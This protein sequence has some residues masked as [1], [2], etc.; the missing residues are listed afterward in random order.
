MNKL[1]IPDI[2]GPEY[3]GSI[4]ALVRNGYV[5]RCFRIAV[6]KFDL[7]GKPYTEWERW[8]YYCRPEVLPDF[9]N[10]I[11]EFEKNRLA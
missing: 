8:I 10:L 5:T 1:V 11:E 9:K 7:F 3:G 4:T 6:Q 2:D